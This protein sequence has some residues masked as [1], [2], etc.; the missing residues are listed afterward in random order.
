[1]ALGVLHA[2]HRRGIRVPD[3]IA[4]VGFDGLPESAEFTPALT[5]VAQPLR[6]LG[7]TAVAQVLAQVNGEPGARGRTI[8][9]PTELI[10][11]D[12]APAMVVAA[13][14]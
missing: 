12:S 8:T 11:R 13:S 5:T 1:M 3:D 4:V 9:L 7:I 6:E 2:A 14:A 10:V